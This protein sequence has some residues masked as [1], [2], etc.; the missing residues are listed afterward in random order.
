[1]CVVE[2][3]NEKLLIV[4]SY[5]ANELIYAFNSTTGQRK[6]RVPKKIPSGTFQSVGVAGDG[7]GRLFVADY[8]NSC[9]Q[10]FSASDGQYLGSLLKQGD[11]G[12]GYPCTLRWSEATLSLVVGH[13]DGKNLVYQ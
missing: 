5:E 13:H 10:M 11:Q 9:I 12:L 2:S 3:E 6:W 4:K 1:M 8:T 7:S